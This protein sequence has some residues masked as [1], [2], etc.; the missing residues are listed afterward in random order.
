MMNEVHVEVLHAL[1]K[2]HGLADVLM[3]VSRIVED[4]ALRHRKNSRKWWWWTISA[5]IVRNAATMIGDADA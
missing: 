2:V 4:G 1:I 5:D 3:Q